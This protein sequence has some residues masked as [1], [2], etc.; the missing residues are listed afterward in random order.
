M[1]PFGQYDVKSGS[2]AEMARKKKSIDPK[3]LET[4][5][6]MLRS[7]VKELKEIVNMLLQIVMEE[8][9]IDEFG[10]DF[11]RFMPDNQNDR[12]KLGM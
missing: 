1:N 5:I 7:E 3:A 2:G 10:S 9:A 6:L 4:E 11:Q 12:L 8:D